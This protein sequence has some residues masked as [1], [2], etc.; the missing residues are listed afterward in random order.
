MLISAGQDGYFIRSWDDGDISSLA[1]H[2]NNRKIWDQLRD[3]FPNPYTEHDARAWIRSC[4][5]QIPQT[6]FAIATR[7]EAIGAIG[8]TL[9]QDVYVK[10]AEI[11]Y[12][13]GEEYWRQGIASSAVHMF[14]Q[15]VFAHFPLNRIY[16][17]VFER[18]RA[19]IRV[20]EKNGFELEGRLRES[21]FKNGQY[22]DSVIYAILKNR[23]D[24][25]KKQPRDYP[26]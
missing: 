8:L 24:D 10:S 20:L 14:M 21:V 22:M 18:N 11:G 17:N 23:V 2:A 3:T 26:G 25:E 15:Y 9:Q 5:M 1:R 12:W 6:N 13:L 19:S 7:A 4:L 16:A